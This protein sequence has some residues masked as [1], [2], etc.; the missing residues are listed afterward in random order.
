MDPQK[1]LAAVSE[2]PMQEPF[3]T[4]RAGGS[5]AGESSQEAKWS[6]TQRVVTSD[7]RRCVTR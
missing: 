2:G 5:A 1:M 6:T 7:G 3:R 4:Q